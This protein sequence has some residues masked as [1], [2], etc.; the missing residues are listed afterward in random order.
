M[1]RSKEEVLGYRLQR[2][3]DLIG[4]SNDNEY[5]VALDE[6][7]VFS[8]TAGALYVW[9]L[10]NGE[11]TVRDIIDKISKEANIPYSEL[12]QPVIDLVNQLLDLGLV[13]IK[14]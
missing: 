9:S 13:E 14:E 4:K 10:C 1:S 3:G 2:K 8:M 7:H 11:L 12:E 5:F 6:E